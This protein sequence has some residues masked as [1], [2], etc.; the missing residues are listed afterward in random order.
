[1]E[2]DEKNYLYLLILLPFLVALFLYNQY[3]KKKKQAEFGDLNLINKLSPEKSVFKSVLKFVVFCVALIGIIIGLVN[4]KIGTRVENVKREGIDIVFAVDVSKSMLCEDIAPNRLEKSKQLVS[5][6]MAHLGDDRVGIIAYAGSAYPVLPITT[7]FNSAK[8]MLQSMNTDM[9]SSVGTSLVEA[10][11]LSSQFFEKNN[12]TSKLMIM[13]TDGEDHSEGAEDAANEAKKLGLKII[14]IGVGTE[15][16][17][18]IPL[19]ENGNLLGYKNDKQGNQVTTK[20]NADILKKIAKST[21]GGYIDGKNTKEVVDFVDNEL[22]KIQKNEFE[23]TQMTNYQAQFQWFLGL[24]F[25]LLLLDVFFLER[26][27]AWVK[28]ADL[29]NEKSH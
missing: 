12:K 1:M 24:A 18:P 2:L 26:K 15:N 17:G 27:T 29:F 5:Q 6:I 21:N 10:I 23:S 4:P 19:K 7:D 3:W 22:N 25:F 14:T 20:M 8:M 16:G 11:N 13:I 9:L 28:K